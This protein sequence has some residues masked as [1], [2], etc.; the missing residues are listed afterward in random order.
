MQIAAVE[1][2]LSYTIAKMGVRLFA[3]TWNAEDGL[4]S[5]VFEIDDPIN[6]EREIFGASS[7]QA[8]ILAIKTLSAYLYG[9]DLY[10]RAELGIHGK[11]GGDLFI[12]ATQPF[13]EAAPYP[14]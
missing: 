8:L 7:L 11:F 4:W 2:D 3:P 14:F 5:C 6:L 10:K 13:L 9:S 12:P 1:F